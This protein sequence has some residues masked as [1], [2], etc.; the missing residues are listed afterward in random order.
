MQQRDRI[1]GARLARIFP[2]LQAGQILG[3]GPFS[4]DDLRVLR[5]VA[6]DCGI[7]LTNLAPEPAGVEEKPIAA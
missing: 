3:P 1:L 5:Q 2:L 6:T 4:D 7:D